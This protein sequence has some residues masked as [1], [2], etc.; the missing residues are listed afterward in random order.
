MPPGLYL[1]EVTHPTAKI[2]EQ[3]NSNTVLGK[4]LS[5]ETIYRG[6]LAVDLKL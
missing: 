4:E 1:V 3:Y 5:T 6:K 2:P